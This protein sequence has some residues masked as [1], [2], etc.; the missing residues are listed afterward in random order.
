[1]K[2]QVRDEKEWPLARTVFEKFYLD[3][4]SGGMG[5]LKAGDES[6]VTY[7]AD[8]RPRAVHLSL[9]HHRPCWS[10]T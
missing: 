3:G 2:A 6:V 7:A 4:R 1:M 10:G 9:Q 8:H 5:P